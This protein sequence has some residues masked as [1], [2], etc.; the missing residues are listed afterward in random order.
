MLSAFLER[1]FNFQ[2]KLGTIK[3]YSVGLT[4]GEKEYIF[5]SFKLYPNPFSSQLNL[6][7]EV[8]EI[9]FYN[10][11]GEVVLKQFHTKNINTSHLISGVYIVH[12]KTRNLILIDKIVKN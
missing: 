1:F 6:T 5:T 2:A 4:L 9:I 10:V 11:L 7:S 12:I 8:D 3:I